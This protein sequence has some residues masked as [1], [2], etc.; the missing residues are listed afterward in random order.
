MICRV[1]GRSLH[2][3]SP[4]EPDRQNAAQFLADQPYGCRWQNQ[5]RPMCTNLTEMGWLVDVRQKRRCSLPTVSHVPVK[6]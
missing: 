1:N 2:P 3:Y 6:P 4:P 5:A